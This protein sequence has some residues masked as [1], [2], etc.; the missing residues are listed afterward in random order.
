[1]FRR[2][3]VAPLAG[4]IVEAKRVIEQS[5]CVLEAEHPTHGGVDERDRNPSRPNGGR[6]AVGVDGVGHVDV[7]AG[8]EGE[9]T[10]LTSVGRHSV[11]DQ[12]ADA[13]PVTND[14]ALE[15]AGV[16]PRSL[17]EDITV[18]APAFTPAS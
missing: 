2:E 9:N 15:S 12:L 10:G 7:D 13:A 4:D 16:P 18:A 3:S 8:A 11:V 6:H 5:Q 17:K 14:Q 1:M